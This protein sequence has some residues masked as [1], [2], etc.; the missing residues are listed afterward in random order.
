MKKAI[1]VGLVCSGLL[2]PLIC[3]S[4]NPSWAAED[5]FPSKSIDLVCSFPAGGG[6]LDLHN[7]LLAKFLEKEL[8]VTVV[9]LNKPGGGG[10][11]AGALLANAR[12]DGYTLA[13]MA[14][15]SIIMPILLKEA[16]FSL[17]DFRIIGQVNRG[18]PVVMIV[19]PDSPWKTFKEFVDYAKANPGIKWVTHPLQRPLH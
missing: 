17:Q 8:K 12:P 6:P 15:T 10:T 16:S 18:F 3:T 2:F 1:L 19:P 4:L 5:K 11:L 14:E 9:P 13:L 7:R